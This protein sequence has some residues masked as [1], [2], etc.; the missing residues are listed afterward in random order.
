MASDPQTFKDPQA[1]RDHR[2]FG[3]P[4]L[5]LLG[6]ALIWGINI[7]VM[8]NGLDGMDWYSFNALRLG[9][10]AIVLA[11]PAW[12]D[13]RQ[14]ARRSELALETIRWRQILIYTLLASVLY[15]LLF[16]F[17][18][19]RTASGNAGLI[20]ST[21]PIWTVVFARIFLAELLRWQA[22]LGLLLAFSGTLVVTLQNLSFLTDLNQ[23]G[24]NLCLLG[25]AM[26]WG[27]STVYSRPLMR[28]MSPM[29]LSFFASV[30]SLP[31]H[32]LLAS[33]N[34]REGVTTLM[35]ST[36][37]KPLTYSGVCS[38]GIALVFWN[39]GV[40]HAGAGQAAIY[41]NL[42]PII[43]IIAAW[44]LR[45]ETVTVP[46]IIGG[47]MILAGLVIVRKNRIT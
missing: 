27:L 7:P 11:F 2:A 10:S 34:L 25:A 43:A 47:V 28:L 17:G 19:S 9:L 22:W 26:V 13:H 15:Q 45:G 40:R 24:G 46:Q 21:I 23:L 35:N 18:V 16:L 3:L 14:A 12:L 41:Q 39:Y 6:V 32:F 44:L 37:W 5:A 8:K 30:F 4:D 1:S 33:P 42:V 36:V 29:R 31:V 38:T 20:L